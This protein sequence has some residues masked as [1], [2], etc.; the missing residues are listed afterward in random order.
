MFKMYC[1]ISVFAVEIIQSEKVFCV[2]LPTLFH[3][4]LFL[5]EDLETNKNTNYI[6][7]MCGVIS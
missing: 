7:P 3:L 2:L 5:Q 1:H 6:K 4:S